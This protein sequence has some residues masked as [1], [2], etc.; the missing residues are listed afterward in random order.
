MSW[1]LPLLGLAIG[2]TLGWWLRARPYKSEGDSPPLPSWLAGLS[3]IAL[4]GTF[5]FLVWQVSDPVTLTLG[6]VFA[7]GGLVGTWTDL[8]ERRL[9]DWLTWSLA[10]ALT[11]AV[12]LGAV[13]SGEWEPAIR[14]ILAG[15]V[16]SVAMFL[17]AIVTSLGLGDVKLGIALGLVLGYR[18]WGAVASG[19]LAGLLIGFV[20]AIVLLALGRPAKSHLPFGPA[21]ILGALLVFALDPV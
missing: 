13:A 16:V 7:V 18:S 14:A 4:A 3:G 1:A 5:A 10:G 8:D 12:A 11:L 21:L 19:L 6:C 2:A 15:A 20:W 9:P 17:L